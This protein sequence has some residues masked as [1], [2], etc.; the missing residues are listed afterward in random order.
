MYIKKTKEKEEKEKKVGMII[1]GYV[2][3]APKLSPFKTVLWEAQGAS[4][5]PPQLK[6]Q[7]TNLDVVKARR[8]LSNT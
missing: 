1:P 3:G 5:T 6:I 7:A 4:A 2:L 8:S